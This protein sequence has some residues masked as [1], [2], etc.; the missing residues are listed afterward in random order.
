[1]EHKR[2]LNTEEIAPMGATSKE[3]EEVEASTEKED[4]GA[5]LSATTNS[6]EKKISENSSKTERAQS[7]TAHTKGELKSQMQSIM[8]PL[9]FQIIHNLNLECIKLFG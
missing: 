5:T 9:Y 1:M 2:E 7:V 3:S 6:K 8:C 4:N